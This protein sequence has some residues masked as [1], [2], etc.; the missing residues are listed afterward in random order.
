MINKYKLVQFPI[1]TIF[2][3][4]YL[5]NKKYINIKNIINNNINQIILK[6]HSFY[7][8]MYRS[9]E[10][11][12]NKEKPTILDPFER[13]IF[14]NRNIFF[15]FSIP[16]NV[17]DVRKKYMFLQQ[18]NENIFYTEEIKNNMMRFFSQSQKTY[19]AFSKL[20]CH[21]KWKKSKLVIDKDLSL[22]TIQLNEKNVICVY[23]K[24]NRYLFTTSDLINIFKTALTYS[25]NFFS[26]PLTIKNPYNNIPFSK[27]NLCNIYFTI[28][29]KSI[30][31]PEVIQK[32][33][34]SNFD[35]D[36]FEKENQILLRECAI[37]NFLNNM[38]DKEIVFKV[39]Y[40]L[41]CYNEKHYNKIK[42]DPGFPVEKIISIFK[43]YL[44]LF[45][46]SIF[47]LDYQKKKDYGDVLEKML[48]RLR[49]YF[50]Q[51]GRKIVKI[52]P[53]NHSIFRSNFIQKK[54][55]FMEKDFIQKKLK[56]KKIITFNNEHPPFLCNKNNKY[57]LSSHLGLIK[58]I[59]IHEL[60]KFEKFVIHC[61]KLARDRIP[62]EYSTRNNEEIDEIYGF[63]ENSSDE[64]TTNNVADE[65]VNQYTDQDTDDYI[66]N[67]Y[68]L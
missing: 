44:S 12:E 7:K 2:P 32:Y 36:L 51:F 57:F 23:H 20:A 28:F 41:K 4:K 35:L 59:D 37:F 18:T 56:F 42:L 48:F 55:T 8:I 16:E 58:T 43:P 17:E 5:Y 15:Y 46:I 68:D 19:F 63:D 9:I 54:E 49:Y 39:K 22:N 27:S 13:F 67:F 60:L 66:M 34:Q 62:T 24:E 3:S 21:Y 26:L 6:M 1:F 53:L 52:I 40:M 14:L 10:K 45:Y 47:S 33:F 61:H 30:P 38:D 31:I 64:N 50:P 65:N 11:I 29:F 25:S